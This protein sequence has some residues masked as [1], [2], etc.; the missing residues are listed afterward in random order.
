MNILFL[1]IVNMKNIEEQGIYTDLMREFICNGHLVTICSTVEKRENINTSFQ[2]NEK[3]SQLNIKIGNLTKTNIIS[4]GISLITLERKVLRGIKK[5]TKHIRFD[6]ILYHTPP[7]TFVKTISYI[8]KRDGAKAYLLLKDIFPQNAVDLGMFKKASIFYYWFRK[9]EKKLYINS[10]FIGCMSRANVDYVLDHNKYINLDKVE[11]CPNSIFPVDILKSL[12]ER[13][14]VR[15]LYGIPQNKII[16]LY[17]GNL[18]KPQGIEFIIECVKSN[19]NNSYVH[20]V[21]VGS[22]TEYNKVEQ[23][24]KLEKPINLTLIRQLPKEKYEQLVRYSDVGLIFLNKR[25][26][27]PNF[28]SR[29]L[30][31]LQASLPVIASTDVSTDVGRIIEAHKIGYWCESNNVQLFNEKITLLLDSERREIMGEEGNKFLKEHYHVKRTYEII[32]KHF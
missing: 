25:F 8:K 10:D 13:N 2:K 28:P 6:L 22:G 16:L 21:L 30:S 9:K 12:E 4:K 19:I 24:V 17:G 18:G 11:E 5:Y 3:Y 32:M 31:Y 27:I 7:I 23:F 1:T 29:L 20:F 14:T 15:E 26:T